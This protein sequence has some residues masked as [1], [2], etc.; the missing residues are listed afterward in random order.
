MVSLLHD[1]V[2]VNLIAI[3]IDARSPRPSCRE[4]LFTLRSV[5]T[6]CLSHSEMLPSRY[7]AQLRWPGK[8][9]AVIT[10]QRLSE[11]S[12]IAGNGHYSRGKV[13]MTMGAG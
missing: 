3:M 1:L 5:G 4:T 6:F 10:L 7:C 11:S 8:S 12:K 13:T 2:L 9:I